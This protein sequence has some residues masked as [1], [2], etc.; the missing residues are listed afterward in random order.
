V[1]T[2]V[3]GK[4]GDTAP[5]RN[6]SS[7]DASGTVLSRNDLGVVTPD[8][9]HPQAVGEV[10]DTV[11]GGT[12]K[13][14]YDAM[15][16]RL[17][18]TAAGGTTPSIIRSTYTPFNKPT[19]IWRQG[20]TAQTR[21]EEA[22]YE[23]DA[24]GERV[25]KRTLRQTPAEVT[26]YAG[27]YERRDRGSNA[28]DHV[29]LIRNETRVVAQVTIAQ[30]GTTTF[31]APEVRYLHDDHLGSTHVVSTPTGQASEERSYD[32]WGNRRDPKNWK[33][34]LASIPTSRIRVGYTGHEDDGFGLINMGGR[35]YDP[36]VGQLTTAD[37]GAGMPGNT[38]SHQRYSYVL[39]NPLGWVD[40]S[41]F[42]PE[43]LACIAPCILVTPEDAWR[44]GGH[45]DIIRD[46]YG[47]RAT[48][49][50]L[51]GVA[52]GANPLPNPA[53]RPAYGNEREF[54]AGQLVG[55]GIGLLADAVIGG[56]GSGVS[57]TG[58]GAVVGVVVVRVAAVSAAAHLAK[59]GQALLTLSK[60]KGPSAPPAPKEGAKSSKAPMLG[61]R[62]TQV[63]SK[64]VYK[65]SGGRLDVENP[66]PGSRPGQLHFQ[67]GSEKYLY[68]PATRSFPGAPS[69]VSELLADPKFQAGIEKGLRYLG[70]L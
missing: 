17:T 7:F 8:P 22:Q 24:D 19:A 1:H 40:P 18:R 69:K 48:Y 27:L 3:T 6:R 26:T 59:G 36:A 58:A 52:N 29:F 51:T 23:Y 68:D 70:E 64:T 15:G 28:I 49:D 66:A 44:P 31:S 33:Q 10:L 41:G 61:E 43:G 56:A 55:A 21:M 57:G 12:I 50:F 20:S 5:L 63:T 45:W 34:K 62:G 30:T 9:Q 67:S 53:S 35:F 38:Q 14:Q 2:V 32:V 25:I 54:A 47:I 16:N 13:Y 37:P 4:T 65:G 60:A 11:N 39:N 42:E 46:S